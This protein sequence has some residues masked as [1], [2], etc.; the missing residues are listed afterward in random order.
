MIRRASHGH[1]MWCCLEDGVLV[2]LAR[3]TV[4]PLRYVICDIQHVNRVHST[5]GNG[6]L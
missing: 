5:A 3:A 4:A 6:T 2:S 1:R